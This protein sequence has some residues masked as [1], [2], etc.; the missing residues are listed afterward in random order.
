MGMGSGQ[1]E[2]VEWKLGLWAWTHKWKGKVIHK[3]KQYIKIYVGQQSA[4]LQISFGV[5]YIF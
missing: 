5:F 4:L 3:I 1:E 2:V